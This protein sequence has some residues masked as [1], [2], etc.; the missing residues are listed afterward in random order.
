MLWYGWIAREFPNTLHRDMVD[1]LVE[2]LTLYRDRAVV[3][4]QFMSKTEQMCDKLWGFFYRRWAVFSRFAI[5]S[6]QGLVRPSHVSRS[7]RIPRPTRHP[8]GDW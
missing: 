1:D 2:A 7:Y 8:L 5:I 3:R 4:N 6:P